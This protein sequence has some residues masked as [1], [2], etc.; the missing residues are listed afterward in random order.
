MKVKENKILE[1]SIMIV[2][3]TAVF[4]FLSINSVT[5]DQSEATY[6]GTDACKGCHLTQYEL[7]DETSHGI[8]FFDDSEW[9]YN[10][11]LTDKYVRCGDS[12]LPCHTIGY[13]EIDKGGYDPAYAWDSTE[14]AHL[15]GIGCEN[16]HGPG[17]EHI[18]GSD[19]KADINQIVDQYAGSC[20][21]TDD[22]GCHGGTRQYGN[23]TIPGWEESAHATEAP[24]YAQTVDCMSCRS[25]EGFIANAE[26]D[27][28][29]EIPED[30]T[31]T[32]TCGACHDPHPEAT[33]T[34]NFQLRLSED[35]ICEAC[36][37]STSSLG[38]EEVHHPQV[39]M[40]T[41]N[42]GVDVEDTTYMADVNCVECHHYNSPHGTNASEYKQ[43]HS[44]V[45]QPEA[46]VVCHDGVIALPE[47]NI[48]TALEDIE[49]QHENFANTY[50]TVSPN[51]ET[52]KTKKAYADDNKIWTKTGMNDTY[53]EALWNFGLATA[54][55]SNG[56]HNPD[57]TEALMLDANTKA[58]EV[59]AAVDSTPIPEEDGTPG[60]EAVAFIVAIG[61]AL[62]LLRKR[63]K[64]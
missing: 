42:V 2:V 54:D 35:E 58:L 13:N 26:G 38:S 29:T 53:Y 34:N 30:T 33:N 23:Q 51:I 41:G 63:I 36:H 20:G 10:D 16:C 56:T 18:S 40:R 19:K 46:C 25:T 9:L 32:I 62:I 21:G 1:V 24:E 44:W 47:Y 12:M 50:A 57:Y 60:F 55:G 39:E 52:M 43:G 22:A 8:Y 11:V 14:N 61:I 4:I 48:T 5:A 3:F 64:K 28:L 37:Y 6:S 7:W 31:W 27:P 49:E 17:S 15:L 45:P 59:I